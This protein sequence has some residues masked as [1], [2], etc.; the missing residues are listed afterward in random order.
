MGRRRRAVRRRAVLKGLTGSLRRELAE[1]RKN[2]R[3]STSWGR[4][5]R[6]F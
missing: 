1:I 3:R 6:R 5:R 2:M 4:Q